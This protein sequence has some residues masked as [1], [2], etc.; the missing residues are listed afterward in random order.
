MALTLCIASFR[1]AAAIAGRY[2]LFVGGI[3]GCACPPVRC[4]NLYAEP[5]PFGLSAFGFLASLLP[6]GIVVSLCRCD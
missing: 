6:F 1:Q 2:F 4:D 5:L 3:M